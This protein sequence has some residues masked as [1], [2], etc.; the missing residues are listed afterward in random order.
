VHLADRLRAAVGRTVRLELDR[1]EPVDGTVVEA[2]GEWVLVADGATRRAL[3]PVGGI[4]GVQGLDPSVAPPAGRVEQR[5]G[6][7]HALRALARDRVTVRIEVTGTRWR[8]RLERVGAD[9]VDVSVGPDV[10]SA[11]VVTVP[12]AALRVVATL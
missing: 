3:V 5:L 10:R 12:F 2:T 4:V 8:G 6:L 7:G 1:A 11:T 9:H